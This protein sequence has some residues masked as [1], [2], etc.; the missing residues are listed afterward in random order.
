MQRKGSKVLLCFWQWGHVKEDLQK[1]KWKTHTVRASTAMLSRP[2]KRQFDMP[3]PVLG[4]KKFLYKSATDRKRWSLG[5]HISLWR[6]LKKGKVQFHRLEVPTLDWRWTW[7]CH[8]WPSLPLQAV[9]RCQWKAC[10]KGTGTQLPGRGSRGLLS[11]QALPHTVPVP[12]SPPHPA[13]GQSFCRVLQSPTLKV[14]LQ[15]LAGNNPNHCALKLQP[16]PTAP[17]TLVP[18]PSTAY[19]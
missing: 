11:P 13:A 15:P 1:Q 5:H 2:Y 14:S 18:S 9:Q 3:I 10:A 12:V 7:N 19:T 16:L 6:W 17:L 4:L 8:K